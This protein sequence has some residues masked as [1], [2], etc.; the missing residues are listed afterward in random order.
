MDL[1]GESIGA[2]KNEDITPE[3]GDVGSFGA[4]EVEG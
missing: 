3:V 1:D 4:I 2:I